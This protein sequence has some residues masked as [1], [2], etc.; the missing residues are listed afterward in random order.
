MA[1]VWSTNLVL[2]AG[3]TAPQ[4]LWVGPP[5]RGEPLEQVSE[6][7][8]AVVGTLRV[9]YLGNMY[10][11][12]ALPCRADVGLPDNGIQLVGIDLPLVLTIPLPAHVSVYALAAPSIPLQVVASAFTDVDSSSAWGAT[13]SVFALAAATVPLMPWCQGVSLHDP[14]ATATW[15]DVAA[16]A[17][18][19]FNGYRPRPRRAVSL[20]VGATNTMVTQHFTT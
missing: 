4:Q 5:E 14:A 11:P 2:P 12:T 17:I 16:T 3:S 7:V 18:G 8:P 13:Q 19:V 20:L 6:S 15:L 10:S 9:G 1:D